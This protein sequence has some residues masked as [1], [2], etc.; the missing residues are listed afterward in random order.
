MLAA[1]CGRLRQ[2]LPRYAPADC[3]RSPYKGTAAICR[4]RKLPHISLVRG[5]DRLDEIAHLFLGATGL[6]VL[7]PPTAMMIRST[8]PPPTPRPT[9]RPSTLARLRAMDFTR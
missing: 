2:I 8:P 1:D 3:G 4:Y 9:P 5:E 6:R 7:C